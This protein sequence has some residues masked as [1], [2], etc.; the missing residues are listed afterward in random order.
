MP[1]RIE[2]VILRRTRVAFLDR[3][4]AELLVPYVAAEL[5]KSLGWTEQ[6]MQEKIK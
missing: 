3:N 6:Q 2:D 5:G 1:T 4:K